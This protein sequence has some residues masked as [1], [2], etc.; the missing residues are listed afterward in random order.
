MKTIGFIDYYIDE[1]HAQNLPAWIRSSSKAGQFDIHLAWE[2]TTP[3]GKMPLAT[4]CAEHKVG[5][6][7]SIEQ[8]V[9]E[10]DCFV[11]LSPDNAERHEDLADLPLRS[12]KPVYIDKPIAPSLAAAKRLFDKAAAHGTPM[13]SSSALRYADKFTAALRE[14]GANG[15]TFAGIRGSGAFHIYAIHQIEMAVMAVGAGACRVMQCGNGDSDLMVIDYPDGRRASIDLLRGYMPFGAVVGWDGGS[16]AVDDVGDIFPPFVESMLE[17]F[18]TGV[19]PIQVRETLE[20]A[21]LIEAG[22]SALS[23]RDTWIRV[24]E[25]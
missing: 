24:P 19:S 11:V 10:C 15:I 25:V 9:E 21:A 8:V 20:I 2:E 4:W 14:S 12:G 18:S 6:A 22:Q 13:M 23:A 3:E 16:V 5:M 17:F 1:W 7:T